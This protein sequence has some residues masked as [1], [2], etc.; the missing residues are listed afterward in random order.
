MPVTIVPVDIGDAPGDGNGVVPR[1]AFTATN[2]S[3]AN[4]KAAVDALLGRFWTIQ[5]TGTALALGGRYKANNHAGITFTLPAVF[6]QAADSL[7]DIWCSNADDASD[8]TLTP[9]SGDA[10]FVDGATLGVDV[11]HALTP[12]QLALLSP[13]T[14]DSEW[15]VVI[16]SSGGGGGDF[17]ADGSVDMTGAFRTDVGTFESDVAD[18]A[19]AVAF[20]HNTAVAFATAGAKLDR[21]RNNGVEKFYIDKDG[22]IVGLSAGSASNVTIGVGSKNTGLFERTS[23]QIGFSASGSERWYIGGIGYAFRSNNSN[24]AGLFNKAATTTTPTLSPNHSDEDTGVGHA[25]ADQ[26]SFIAGGVEV[27]RAVEDTGNAFM[28]PTGQTVAGLPVT[29]AVGMIARVTDADTP[30]IGSTVVGGGAAA[31]LCWYN[32]SNWTVMG[33]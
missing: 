14:T 9:A 12:G 11:S 30:A 28:L 3:D 29:P 32:G 1:I 18:G 4:L 6:G 16:L 8:V 21:W 25:G 27:A 5:N 17:K 20:D 31:A 13:R 7:S 26:L 19:S 2:D 33:I 15:D 22:N 10:L 24:G 23:N